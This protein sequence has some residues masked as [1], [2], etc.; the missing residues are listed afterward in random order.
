MKVSNALPL[1]FALFY[2]SLWAVSPNILHTISDIFPPFDLI[3][4]V[5]FIVSVVKIL[6]AFFRHSRSPLDATKELSKTHFTTT[7]DVEIDK[8]LKEDK[9][10]SRL[11]K[12]KTMR[13][14]KLDIRT[15][16][17]IED[18]LKHMISVIRDKGNTIDQREIAELTHGLKQIAQKESIL[19]R[20]MELIR[21]HLIAYKQI[22]RKD[23]PELE[24]RLAEST[25]RKTQ[26][27][28]QEQI[29]YQKRMLQALEFMQRYAPKIEEFTKSLNRLVFMAMEKMKSA[30]PGDALK[31]LEYA[32]RDMEQMKTTYEK[33]KDLEKYLLRINKKTIRDLK[34]EKDR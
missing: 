22:H 9:K 2:A 26:D 3:L 1:G 27:I 4:L 34:K 30:Y 6:R 7:D 11:L 28:I 10:E 31:Y 32:C 21:R 18:C 25:D 8:E 16:E 5:L 14:T 13:L 29:T 17:D 33:Q 19:K 12:R 20:G 24:K 15:I 23:I